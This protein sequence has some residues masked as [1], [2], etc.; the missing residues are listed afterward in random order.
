MEKK[1]LKANY[2]TFDQAM[3]AENGYMSLP[4]KLGFA[5]TDVLTRMYSTSEIQDYLYIRER[6]GQG[7]YLQ[8]FV[9]NSQ[10]VVNREELEV[11]IEE[12]LGQF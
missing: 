7:C 11:I 10:R 3:K 2:S 6:T 5:I 1:G 8:K 4:S 9:K 12:K